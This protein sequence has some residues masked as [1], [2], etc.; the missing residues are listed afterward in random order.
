MSTE[1]PQP[2]SIHYFGL[3]ER[4]LDGTGQSIHSRLRPVTR[5]LPPRIEFDTEKYERYPP[6]V[7]EEERPLIE[8]ARILSIGCSVASQG[9]AL[10][11]EVGLGCG[12]GGALVAADG[13]PVEIKHLG[14]MASVDYFD[15]D[16]NKAAA[17]MRHLA[18]QYP[19]GNLFAVPTKI[20]GEML[21]QLLRVFE[22]NVVWEVCDSVASGLPGEIPMKP[23]SRQIVTEVTGGRVP[24][25]GP[26]DVELMAATLVNDRGESLF[27][28][29]FASLDAYME[30]LR[31]DPIELIRMM[32]GAENISPN[33][34]EMIKQV[35]AGKKK[36]FAQSGLASA[37]SGIL[38][39]GATMR[40]VLGKPLTTS[41]TVDIDK[42]LAG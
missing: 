41:L 5:E 22:P 18:E 10:A 31:A 2:F 34:D 27:G 28:G 25:F 20:D 3:T 39:V 14:R 16:E 37:L 38:L 8:G 32:V 6:L 9:L 26:T 1:S 33:M 12:W 29:N 30:Q 11:V 42:L 4:T 24:V 19:Y 21:R 7:T 23:L 36:S 15:K 40:H 35:L 13:A 17:V